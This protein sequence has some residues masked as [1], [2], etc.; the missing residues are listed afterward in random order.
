[1]NEFE[2]IDRLKK[3]TGMGLMLITHDLG[4]VAERSEKTAIM[5]AGKIVEY[6][7]TGEIFLNPLHP[8][9]QMLMA[10][11]PRLD[12]KWDKQINVE[13]TSAATGGT[14]GT[15]RNM[16]TTAVYTISITTRGLHSS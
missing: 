4:I 3:Q 7:K 15:A 8:Y 11:V 13:T 9:T 6:A 12:Q 5:Y 2:L 1:M 16:P 10:S 14:P